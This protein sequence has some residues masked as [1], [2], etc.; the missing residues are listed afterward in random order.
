MKILHLSLKAKWYRMIESGEK[1]EEYR[2]IKHYWAFRLY[3]CFDKKQRKI[4]KEMAKTHPD[5]I[6]CNKCSLAKRI[7]YERVTFSL[8]Y[9]KADDALR[10]MTFEYRGLSCGKGRPEFGAPV[11]RAVFIIK[12]G[13]RIDGK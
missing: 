8:G 5:G 13:E 12:L 1:P 3:E 9:P 6:T 11:D 4:C 7:P 2:E 10:H